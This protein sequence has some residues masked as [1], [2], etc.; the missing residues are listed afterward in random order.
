[1]AAPHPPYSEVDL[2]FDAW[3]GVLDNIL[4]PPPTAGAE[5]TPAGAL[6]ANLRL[7]A[8]AFCC[9]AQTC[10]G[11]YKAAVVVLK[12]YLV[13]P[14]MRYK[15]LKK[16]RGEYAAVQQSLK[17]GTTM[18]DI[19]FAHAKQLWLV[20]ESTYQ[21][22]GPLTGNA[23]MTVL[24]NCFLRP[25]RAPTFHFSEP[26]ATARPHFEYSRES[27]VSERAKIICH[28]P[29]ILVESQAERIKTYRPYYGCNFVDY[30]KQ[31]LGFQAGEIVT[32]TDVGAAMQRIKTSD[33]TW[34]EGG[35]Y[36]GQS[37]QYKLRDDNATG[38]ILHNDGE[39]YMVATNITTEQQLE[40]QSKLL[41]NE[42]AYQQDMDA[43]GGLVH[44]TWFYESCC[45]SYNP[46][47]IYDSHHWLEY[48]HLMADSEDA[49]NSYYNSSHRSGLWL[50]LADDPRLNAHLWCNG[51]FKRKTR[52]RFA[53]DFVAR[54]WPDLAD[55]EHVRD[56]V[57]TSGD[58]LHAFQGYCCSLP[59]ITEKWKGGRH[60]SDFFNFA[61]LI[62]DHLSATKWKKL[63]ANV[64]ESV[65]LELHM[66]HSL[67][68]GGGHSDDDRWN[69]DFRMRPVVYALRVRGGA[70]PSPVADH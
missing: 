55:D 53:L 26:A 38:V 6:D 28:F 39:H 18:L 58:L 4:V 57:T 63:M 8:Q 60:A 3:V 47:D 14:E 69:N 9:C 10:K 11:A 40:L 42:L 16:Q 67:D 41:E 31:H 49:A 43:P 45:L 25:Y 35:R 27:L 23:Q 1:M 32:L 22:K 19:M 65:T 13:H 68:S 21:T 66:H 52:L 7:A 44:N 59:T 51:H 34:T 30:T 56:Y 15:S 50:K 20:G 48:Q 17:D 54:K 37:R 2:N 12:K 46:C 36:Y 5:T 64:D 62:A 61:Q 29:T 24:T 33:G 70:L